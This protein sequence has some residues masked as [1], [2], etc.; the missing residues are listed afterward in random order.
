L[1]EAHAMFDA[2]PRF[3][4]AGASWMIMYHIGASSALRERWDLGKECVKLAG[5][6]SGSMLAMAVGAGVPVSTL[7]T[8]ALSQ[9]A[10]CDQ[11]VLGPLG[12]MSS[13]SLG[14]A[15]SFLP[16]D[17]HLRLSHR[18]RVTVTRAVLCRGCSGGEHEQQQ[19]TRSAHVTHWDSNEQ[20]MDTCLASSHIPGYFERPVTLLA[21]NVHYSSAVDAQARLSRGL[22]ASAC[23]YCSMNSTSACLCWDGGLSDNVPRWLPSETAALKA[24]AGGQRAPSNH[25]A[26]ATPFTAT[27]SPEPGAGTISP[28]QV[29][30]ATPRG[31]GLD[32]TPFCSSP[33]LGAGGWPRWYSLVPPPPEKYWKVFFAGRA[34]AQAWMVKHGFVPRGAPQ[35]VHE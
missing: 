16:P 7:V 21:G 25:A 9:A 29:G 15:L 28:P 22:S 2:S 23:R 13:V 17:A 11:R 3:G 1:W 35:Q 6:S 30:D 14:G 26:A 19:P 20:L 10:V 27:V 18:L 4:F 31:A 12:V 24:K 33:Q 34:H 5:T 8:K 32:Q